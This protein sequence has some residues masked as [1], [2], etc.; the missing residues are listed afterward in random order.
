M[1]EGPIPPDEPRRLASLRELDVLDTDVE[2]RFERITRMVC[3]LLDVPIAA[4]S[5]V[6]ETRQ[7][8]KSVQGL[9]VR[10]M[11]RCVAFCPHAILGD[12]TMVVNDAH[13]DPRFADNPLVLNDPHIVFYAGHPVRSP[14]GFKV[15]TLCAIDRKPRTLTADQLQTFKEL[16]AMVEVELKALMKSEIQNGLMAELGIGPVAQP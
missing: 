16:A 9:G 4:V 2:A 13:G 5:L 7:W 10:E 14:D 6:D 15:G 8:F 3:R 1:I 11:E 12:E